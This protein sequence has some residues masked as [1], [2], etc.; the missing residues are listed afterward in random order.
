MVAD[1]G[2]GENTLALKVQGDSVVI[3]NVAGHFF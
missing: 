2:V 3:L 1:K